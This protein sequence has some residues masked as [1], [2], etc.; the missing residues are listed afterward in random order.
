MTANVF[1]FCKVFSHIHNNAES[2]DFGVI[3][4]LQMGNLWIRV[5]VICPNTA[6]VPEGLLGAT[7]RVKQSQH[8]NWV[9]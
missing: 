6:Q 4:I 7:Q 5:T 8:E 1:S 3:P 2:T 9:I